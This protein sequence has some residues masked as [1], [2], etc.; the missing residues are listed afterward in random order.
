M[1][2]MRRIGVVAGLAGTAI[3]VLGGIWRFVKWLTENVTAAKDAAG[4]TTEAKELVAWM[5]WYLTGI[6]LGVS[7]ILICLIPRRLW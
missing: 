2:N 3:S 5:P 4:M 1:A 7:V 6:C